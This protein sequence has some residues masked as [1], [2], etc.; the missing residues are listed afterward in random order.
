MSERSKTNENATVRGGIIG[1]QQRMREIG[2]IRIGVK[3]GNTPKA[4]EFIRLTSAD[5]TPLDAAAKIYG[6]EVTKWINGQYQLI[7]QSSEIEVY[8]SPMPISQHYEM[9]T[10]G[11]CQHRCNGQ[12]D[13]LNDC[14]CQC[15]LGAE[16]LDELRQEGKACKL[17]TRLSLILCKLPGV[18]VW[19]LDTG[20]IHAAGELPLTYEGLRAAASKNHMIPARLAAPLRTV[21]RGGVTKKFRVVE[22]RV[23]L[24]PDEVYNHASSSAELPARVDAS[25]GEVLEADFVD[26]V[27]VPEVPAIEAAAE[28]PYYAQLMKAAGLTGE[29]DREKFA[30][31]KGIAGN[32]WESLLVSALEKGFKT[33]STITA[34]AESEMAKAVEE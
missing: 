24:T 9:W 20:S 6:G 34:F 28:P 31:F 21:V 11:G 23:D 18:G 15:D 2:R 8:A 25:T 30:A 1:L 26:A 7:T 14:E 12:Y 17:V 33:W 19:R 3:D 32:R 27:T 29:D 4:I 10:K 22:L 13:S 16:N 5:R